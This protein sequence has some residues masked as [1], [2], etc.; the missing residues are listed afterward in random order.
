MNRSR[1]ISLAVGVLAVGGLLFTA[2]PASA[3]VAVLPEQDDLYG[4]AFAEEE[5]FNPLQLVSFDST[6]ANATTVGTG[7]EI[8]EFNDQGQAAYDVSR[9]ISWITY[10]TYDELEES[11]HFLA[12]IDVATGVSTPIGEILD[13]EGEEVYVL[14]VMVGAD[15][16]LYALDDSSYN[17]W[18][19]DPITAEAT[20][21]A[22][23]G[24]FH[25]FA[26]DPVTDAYYGID[27]EGYTLWQIDVATGGLTEVATWEEFAPDGAFDSHSMQ[28]DSN[29]VLW[30]QTWS[31]E[32]NEIIATYTLGSG[33][34][35]E[36]VGEPNVS[37]SPIYVDPSI[38]ITRGAAPVAPVEPTLAATGSDAG[39]V[40][41]FGGLLFAAGAALVLGRVASRRNAA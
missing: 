23:S 26:Y 25:S 3:A 19:L 31:G 13:T 12:T 6:N 1:R 2:T 27:H 36:V 11:H 35:A 17:L 8:V 7:T 20:L 9:D 22:E 37:G 30:F 33:V 10:Q 29:G 41:L 24:H 32:E 16:V 18:K 28:F 15:G 40:V 21:V 38:L 5:S 4:I 39:P 14:G 34:L